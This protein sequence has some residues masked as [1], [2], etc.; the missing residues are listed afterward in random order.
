M[1][2][3]KEIIAVLNLVL[4]HG[5]LLACSHLEFTECLVVQEH[6]ISHYLS[7]HAWGQREFP[8]L[9]Q[10]NKGKRKS[11]QSPS[12]TACQGKQKQKQKTQMPPGRKQISLISAMTTQTHRH[13][14]NHFMSLNYQESHTGLF[15]FFLS[16]FRGLNLDEDKVTHPHGI[17]WPPTNASH[18]GQTWIRQASTSLVPK[19]STGGL[20]GLPENSYN[21]PLSL[22]NMR[23]IHVKKKHWK[24]S[25]NFCYHQGGEAENCCFWQQ[26]SNPHRF[27]NVQSLVNRPGCP[28]NTGLSMDCFYF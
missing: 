1:K 22:S 26:I 16:W 5:S 20:T 2:S 18:S 27:L 15:L 12:N 17:P 25:L 14:Y 9:R 24:I 23:I 28:L 7:P 3:W 10:K 19:D 8:F 4:S 13:I 6:Q 11:R 21:G